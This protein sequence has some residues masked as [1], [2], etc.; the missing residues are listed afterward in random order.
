MYARIAM[1]EGVNMDVAERTMKQADEIMEPIMSSI[2]G[3]QGS[4]E[5]VDKGSGKFV[6]I[7]FFDT[8]ENMKGAEKVFDED[9]PKALGDLMEDWE[10]RRTSVDRYEIVGD[11]RPE[12]VTA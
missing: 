4:M 11:R 7:T 3:L 6:A 8:E 12:S 1:F 9:M 10:G 2:E 5:L